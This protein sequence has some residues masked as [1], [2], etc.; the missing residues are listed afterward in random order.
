VKVFGF[1]KKD[2]EPEHKFDGDIQYKISSKFAVDAF[3]GRS[4]GK[5]EAGFFTSLGAAIRFNTRK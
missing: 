5:G 2:N 1:I 4:L 3:A